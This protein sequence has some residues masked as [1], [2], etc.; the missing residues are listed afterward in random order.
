MSRER[1]KTLVPLMVHVTGM[2]VQ[3]ERS[4]ATVPTAAVPRRTS[5][6]PITVANPCGIEGPTDVHNPTGGFGDGCF[7]A[8]SV[9]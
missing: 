5:S 1:M 3:L 9:E 8:A 7:R 4:S 6:G 2:A